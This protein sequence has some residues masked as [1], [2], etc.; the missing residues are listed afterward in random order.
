MPEVSAFSDL[1]LLCQEARQRF[2]S[3]SLDKRKEFDEV[4]AL[5]FDAL[6][7]IGRF[8]TPDRWQGSREECV[9]SLLI[10]AIETILAMYYL[11]ESGFWDNALAL[12]RNFTE[13]LTIALAI[14]YDCQ[15]FADWKNKR[16]CFSTFGRIY[17]RA[18]DSPEVPVVEKELLPR[19]KA[20][21]IESSQRFS[22]SIKPDAVRTLVK[23]G[24][25]S[26]E[27]KVA[28]SSFQESRMNTLR[29][30]VLNVV[31]VLVG[32]FDYA[33]ETRRRKHE[34]PEALGIIQRCNSFFQDERLR[35]EET[36]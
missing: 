12:K 6:K 24:E 19:L 18:M 11:S 1:D 28:A 26:L 29:N 35:S 4:I 30:M 32:V 33:S 8:R 27:P 23:N 9:L 22:H 36:S 10:Q 5:C 17:K 3:Q 15:C 7:S 14:G 13:L 34:F 16:K 2:R 21:W 20:Y 31:S 25:V